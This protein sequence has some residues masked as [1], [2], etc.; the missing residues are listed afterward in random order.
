LSAESPVFS[1]AVV[2]MAHL[3]TACVWYGWRCVL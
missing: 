3:Q 2:T 1:Q